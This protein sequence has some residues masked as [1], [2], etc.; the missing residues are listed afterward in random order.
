[1]ALG[2]NRDYKTRDKLIKKNLEKAG[3]IKLWKCK[4]CG[5]ESYYSKKVC[6]R[7]GTER[8]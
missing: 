5:R 8:E 6:I 2:T 3:P 4:K 1:M 7:C